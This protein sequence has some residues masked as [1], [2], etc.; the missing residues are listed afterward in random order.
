VLS[1]RGICFGLIKH[2]EKSYRMWCDVNEEA[3]VHWGLLLQKQTLGHSR[4]SYVRQAAEVFRLAPNRH[5][6]GSSN[7]MNK[8]AHTTVRDFLLIFKALL[9]FYEIP[10]SYRNTM[11]VWLF[12]YILPFLPCPPPLIKFPNFH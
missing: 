2:P 12:C 9:S 10:F 7:G 6:L 4:Y 5:S 8:Y 1:G 11:E 3:L